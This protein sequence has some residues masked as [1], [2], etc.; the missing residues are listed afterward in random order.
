MLMLQNRGFNKYE[1]TLII[2]RRQTIF[3][4]LRAEISVARTKIGFEASGP[5]IIGT[6][7]ENL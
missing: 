7:L 2:I 5:L 3:S 6:R 4:L 1:R